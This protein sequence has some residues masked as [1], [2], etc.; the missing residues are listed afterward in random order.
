MMFHFIFII[1]ACG[2]IAVGTCNADVTNAIL[3]KLVDLRENETLKSSH[4]NLAVL[5]L[6]LCYLGRK[7]S[8]DATCEALEVFDEP[9][10]SIS[11]SILNLCAYAGTGDVFMIQ[12]LLLNCG[13]R[14]VLP[15]VTPKDDKAKTEQ[16]K[17]D[18]KEK[19]KIKV[20]WD[21]VMAQAV[22][23]LGLGTNIT[24]NNFLKY[25]QNI[26]RSCRCW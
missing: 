11:K 13:E 15:E 12:E 21:P 20:E 19:K 14:L 3:T 1:L 26:F 22:A 17:P 4:M 7:D 6:G 9:F 16:P 2:L 18:L 10:S 5:G 24:H 8:T 23:V 25:T